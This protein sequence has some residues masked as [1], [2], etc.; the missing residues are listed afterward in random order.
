AVYV[1]DVKAVK[2]VLESI[3]EM[4]FETYS[5][6]DWLNQVEEQGKLI[7]GILGGIGA[8][9]LLVAA[10]GITNTMIMSIY[11]RTR[12]IGVM[13]VIG[14][15]LKDIRNL[16]LLEAALIGVSGGVIGVMFSYLISFAINKLLTSF[17]AE[18]MMGTEGSDLSII[19]FS[20]VILAIVFSTAIGVL[21]GYYPANRA[22]K[23]SALES[24]KNE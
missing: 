6:Q 9:S 13:K 20:I 2:S 23:I 3:R 21:S 17:F 15:N 19:P 12:E 4:G 22:M 14:A 5:P 11:E 16:F 1:Q 18:N 8:I 10:I 7:Q 24:L